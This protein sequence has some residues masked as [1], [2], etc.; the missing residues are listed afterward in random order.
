MFCQ[1]QSNEVSSPLLTLPQQIVTNSI[2]VFMH[3]RREKGGLHRDELLSI[4]FSPPHSYLSPNLIN[5]KLNLSARWF[6][7]RNWEA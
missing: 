1:S 4:K 3:S 2:K 6:L 5:H 7:M